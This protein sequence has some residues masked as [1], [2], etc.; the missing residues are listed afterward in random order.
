MT[1]VDERRV[2]VEIPGHGET[3]ALT[4]EEIREL[5]RQLR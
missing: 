5:R 3:Y 1:R 4:T 2:Y